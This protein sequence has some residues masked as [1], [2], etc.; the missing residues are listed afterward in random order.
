MTL[1]GSDFV[2]AT[3]RMCCHCSECGQI[4]PRGSECLESVR[5]GKVRKR[6]CSEDCRLTFDD[7][8]WQEKAREREQAVTA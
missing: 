2:K 7:N 6:V 5:F 3:V 8:Y 4:I 1:I